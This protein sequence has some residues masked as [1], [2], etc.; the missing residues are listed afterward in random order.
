MN[1]PHILKTKLDTQYLI[2][3]PSDEFSQ[4]DKNE[5]PPSLISEPE[6]GN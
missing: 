6:D 2:K 1:P 5:L 3:N 4:P